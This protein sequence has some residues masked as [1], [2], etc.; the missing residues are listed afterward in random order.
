ME[1]VVRT[2]CQACHCEC[3]VVVT[4]ED[5]RIT[6]IA[7]DPEHPMN[8]GFICVK[9][10]A[11][12]ELAYHPDRLK[13]PLKRVG[14][15]GE[16]KWERISWDEALDAIAAKLTQVK[17]QYGTE[18][19]AAIHGTGPRRSLT[20][21]LLPYALHSP[22]RIS[23]DLHI[24]FAA[25]IIGE[26]FTVGHPVTME[27]GPD[28]DNA[29]CILVWGG[30]PTNSH[31][32]RGQRILKA[33]RQRDVKLIV[34]DPRKT[35]LASMA[36]LWLQIR[37]G[38][39]D[40]L[41]L[42]MLNTIIE[43]NLFDKD[44]VSKWCL[45]FDQLK[46]AVK[47]F[48]PDKVSEITWIPED[49]IIQAAEMYAGTKPAVVHSRVALNQNLN[50]T[51]TSRAVV[52][53]AALTGNLD[54]KGG[55]LLPNNIEGY[56]PSIALAGVGPWL[57]PDN[58]VKAKQ[59]GSD[60]Y[61]LVA[62]VDAIFPFVPSPLAVD[63]ID[64]GKPYPLKALFCA[65]SNPVV[66]A[67]N[68]KRVWKAIKDRLDLFVVIDFVMTPSAELADFVLPAAT[69]LEREECCDLEYMGYVAAR[70]KVIEPLHESRDELDILID[71]VKRI[72]WANRKSLP[73]DSAAECNEWMLAGT[74][75]SFDDLKKRSII[76]VDPVYRKYETEGF[77]TPSGKVE[78]YSS[79]IARFGY[80]PVPDFKEPPESPAS[81]PELMEDYPL[82]LTT[83]AREI[84]FFCSEGR[85]IPSLR[86]LNPDPLLEI[87]PETAEK[88]GISAG[89]WIYIESPRV[90][91]ERVKLRS[92]LT[93][94]VD[95]RVVNA[96]YGWWFP[97][98][99]GPEHGCFDSNINV[100]LSGDEPRGETCASVATRG[101]LCKVY[102]TV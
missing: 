30:N 19:I 13:Y 89:D 17:D 73:W 31:P 59:I 98:K 65:G 93:E 2:V 29:E 46:E 58:E 75:M 6:R 68:C 55:N 33:K 91:G 97:E 41:A 12:A 4:V 60:K 66:N 53:L 27:T 28:Y 94:T 84:S 47:A 14:A 56:I 76:R 50:S 1:E 11:A 42:G 20:I 77:H 37:P 24:C 45:G 22:N 101:T 79:D 16:G 71:L 49:T 63:A 43:R 7:G 51:Q 26:H 3:G 72:P 67:Q 96:S 44:F 100:I 9:G 57:A 80:S 95:P 18:S 88:L 74:G 21:S 92:R 87:H 32:G 15:R 61:P 82:V 54:I 70:K 52:M 78:L 25:T 83:G 90:R 69:W 35:K 39:D 48:P 38:T 102:K 64:E 81:T 36:D 99:P 40:A 5:G 85:Q 23:V 62:G 8:R 10:K 86:K 34:V